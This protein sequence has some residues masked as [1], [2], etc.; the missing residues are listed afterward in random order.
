MFYKLM[1]ND[2][3]VDLLREV[4][5]V[6]YLPKSKRWVV[7]DQQSAHGVR[8]SNQNTIYLLEG[9]VCAY[10]E[11]LVPVRIEIISEEEYTRLA[12]EVALRAKENESLRNELQDLR[13]QLNEQNNLLQQIL[14]K[15]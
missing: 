14:A 4:C 12:N 3:V 11:E 15:L 8:G 9:R 2:F 7:T 1:N 5:Y 6:R 10:E 13:A